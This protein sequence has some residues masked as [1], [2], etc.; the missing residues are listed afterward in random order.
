ME[1]I[2]SATSLAWAL[3]M[4]HVRPTEIPIHFVGLL[5]E[6]EEKQFDFWLAIQSAGSIIISLSILFKY[7]YTLPMILVLIEV[8]TFELTNI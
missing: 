6:K 5:K 4:Y 7:V 3:L 2:Q 8:F 1:P